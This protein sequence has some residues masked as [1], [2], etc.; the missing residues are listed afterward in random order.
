M[1]L[2]LK[3]FYVRLK[4]IFRNFGKIRYNSELFNN[5]LGTTTYNWDGL[6]TS[7]NSDFIT[8]PRFAKAYQAAKDTNPWPN[9]SL[10]WRI[11]VVCWCAETVKNLEGDFVECGVN[12]G[13][14]ARAIVDYIDFNSTGKTFYLLDTYKGLDPKYITEEEK[15][16][17]I[18]NYNYR[19]TYEEVK[20][21]FAPFRTKIIRGSVPETLS[22]ADTNKICYLSIDMNNVVPE[23]AAAEYFWDKVVPHGIILLDDYGFQAHI[24]QKK[25]FD[26]FAAER[27]HEILSLPTGQ[28]LIIKK[29]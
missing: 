15:K 24:T 17:G 14:Y 3:I 19:D 23:I 1:I 10:Q 4:W 2:K 13:S 20:K 9:F 5:L 16:F 28:G 27:G 21:T 6:A 18:Q 29:K 26:K 12:T 22:Q 11:H 7:A 25:A 8:T